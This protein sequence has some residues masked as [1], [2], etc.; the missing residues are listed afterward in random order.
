MNP[1]L[2]FRN[3]QVDFFVSLFIYDAAL[4]SDTAGLQIAPHNST[5]TTCGV[6]YPVSVRRC[7]SITAPAHGVMLSSNMVAGSD[8]NFQCI[9]GYFLV[10]SQRITCRLDGT[11]S[12][13][14]PTCQSRFGF[15]R[16]PCYI[17]LIFVSANELQKSNE[18]YCVIYVYSSSNQRVHSIRLTQL[19]HI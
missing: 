11:W 13:Q 8:A 6:S 3:L 5:Y 12:G 18:E 9:A 17:W 19:M 15:Q 2:F 7:P 14:P 16:I 1:S 4:K 10:G